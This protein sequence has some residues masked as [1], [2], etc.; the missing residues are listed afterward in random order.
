MKILH[1]LRDPHDRLAVEVAGQQEERCEVAILLIQDGV[2]ARPDV[3]GA[4]VYALDRDV[5]GRG[6]KG[7][8]EPVDYGGAVRLIAEHD[9]VIVW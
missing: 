8:G 5:D 1:I 6:V 2:L 7:A 9:K 3:P 4:T